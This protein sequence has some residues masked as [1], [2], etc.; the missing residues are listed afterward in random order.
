L[1]PRRPSTKKRQSAFLFEIYF[2]KVTGETSTD[3]AT[4]RVYPFIL[5]RDPSPW[6]TAYSWVVMFFNLRLPW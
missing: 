5:F 1:Q 4:E 3:V 6:V 2:K